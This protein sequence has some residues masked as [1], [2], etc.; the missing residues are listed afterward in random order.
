MP[1][2]QGHNADM[3]V[4]KRQP[5]AG[6][7]DDQEVGRACVG[8]APR[9]PSAGHHQVCPPSTRLAASEPHCRLRL[10]AP[11]AR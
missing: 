9:R 3:M 10:P 5:L 4:A 2:C 7:I 6:C 11:T 1:A 8:A